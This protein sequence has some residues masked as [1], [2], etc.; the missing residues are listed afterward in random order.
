MRM[1]GGLKPRDSGMWYPYYSMTSVAIPDSLWDRAE[2]K[3]K[4]GRNSDES[5]AVKNVPEQ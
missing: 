5:W 1:L 2:S 3:T 4:W